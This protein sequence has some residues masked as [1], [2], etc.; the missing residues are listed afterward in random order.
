MKSR[1]KAE[2]QYSK[3]KATEKINCYISSKTVTSHFA[4]T[5]VQG[6]RSKI[7]SGPVILFLLFVKSCWAVEE[8]NFA[9]AG[10][11]HFGG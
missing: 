11:M 1:I 9:N 10:V 8:S 5:L 3:G 6:D 4:E 7:E 2:N